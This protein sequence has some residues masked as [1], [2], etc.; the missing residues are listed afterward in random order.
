MKPNWPVR[1]IRWCEHLKGKKP[2]QITPD[3]V[4]AV[5]AGGKLEKCAAAAFEEMA[6]AA[7]ADGI[8]L[9]ATSAGDTLRSIAQQTAGFIQRYQEAPIAG[10][11]TKTWNGKKYYLKPGM[12]MLATPYDDPA[13]AKARGSRHLYGIAIDIAG[14]NGNSPTLKWL[15]ANEVRF[16]FSH[17]VLGDANG[18]GAE[19]WHIRYTGVRV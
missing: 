18:K 12:A 4:V 1:D 16:G 5:S 8:I 10:A 17:E 15:L 7:K 2:S 19:S 3:M 13:N 9:K 14:T 6:I 11:S